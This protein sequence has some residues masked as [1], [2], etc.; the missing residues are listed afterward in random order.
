MAALVYALCWLL[1]NHHWPWP[2]FYSDA[3]AG[4]SMWVI[5]AVVLWKSRQ[6]TTLEW[7]TLAL[8]VLACC[9]IIWGQYAAGLLKELGQA[10]TS[11]LYLLGLLMALLTGS[12]WER[13]NPGQ[14]ADF[15]FLAVLAGASGSLIVQFQQ[16][17]LINPGDMFWLFLPPPPRRFHANLGQ[18][19]QLATLLCLGVL[20]CGW[21]RERGR[22]S[23]WAAWVWAALLAVGLALT[24][25]RTSWVVIAGSLTALVLWRKQLKIE[26]R[27]IA[28]ALS[29]T[30]FFLLCTVALPHVNLWLGRTAELQELRDIST[31]ELRL[32]YWAKLWQALVAQPWLGYGWMQTSFAQLTS[33]PYAMLTGGTFRHAHNLFLD[34]WVWLGIPLGLTV[35]LI[36]VIWAFRAVLRIRQ[37]EQLWMLLF[38]FALMVHAMLEYPL[39][40]AYFLLP[41][42]LMLGALNVTQGFKPVARMHFGLAASA[43]ALAG[44]GWIVTAYD[45]VRIEENFFTLRFEHERLAKPGEYAEPQVI[46]LTQLQD[47]LWLARVDPLTTHGAPDLERAVRIAKLLPS[48]VGM[49]KLTAM[50]AFAGQPQQAEYWVIVMTR[51]NGLK[52]K[53]VQEIRRQWEEQ[54]AKYPPMADV[55]WPV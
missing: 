45:Y 55:K 12:A 21:L 3:W 41:L 28:A 40:Y 47:M 11:T 16:W 53:T 1:P 44:A 51:M 5:A 9:G 52:Q 10:W 37:R 35:S 18:P 36:L 31:S 6:F 50:Y 27:M 8:L 48:V 29:W 26:G 13:W 43:L 15:L 49:Y 22:L 30:T 24:E 38:V 4:L 42:G 46:A 7:H 25:S 20:A 17:L 34:L 39:Y 2:D 32:I 19:N 33:D 54:A 23:G 14:C